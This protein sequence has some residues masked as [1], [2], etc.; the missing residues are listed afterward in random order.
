MEKSLS[1]IEKK[2][3]NII[4]ELENELG[5]ETGRL[6]HVFKINRGFDFAKENYYLADIEVDKIIKSKGAWY[7]IDDNMIFSATNNESVLAEEAGHFIHH[8]FLNY[9]R[10]VLDEFGGHAIAEMI[11]F[12]SSKLIDK[13]RKSGY[14]NDHI[15]SRRD[16]TAVIEDIQ[17][18]KDEGEFENL[19]HQQGYMLGNILYDKYISNQITKKEIVDLIK[20][21]LDK[22]FEAFGKFIE[23]KYDTMKREKFE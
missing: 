2:V 13:N 17:Y 1:N 3:Y 18:W 22:E 16:V 7:D 10:N 21:P 20:M 9:K 19:V 5:I 15:S 12:F 23:L 8:N 6:P 11:G 14:K 4:F